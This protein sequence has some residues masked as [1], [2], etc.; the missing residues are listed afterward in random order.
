MAKTKTATPPEPRRDGSYHN[1]ETKLEK[2]LFRNGKRQMV[3][4]EFI[5]YRSVGRDAEI[6]KLTTQLQ[7][8]T[9][10]EDGMFMLHYATR[11]I[12]TLDLVFKWHPDTPLYLRNLEEY[13]DMVQQGVNESDLYMYYI[14]NIS[15]Q[16]SEDWTS[17]LVAAQKLWTPP[18]E[19]WD[20][21]FDD[22]GNPTGVDPN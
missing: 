13:W 9:K 20:D 21:E 6:I 17:A 18:E 5:A 19:G 12:Y 22:E 16:V 14:N 8:E 4:G 3:T 15:N 11:R 2:F 1:I 7:E 10:R